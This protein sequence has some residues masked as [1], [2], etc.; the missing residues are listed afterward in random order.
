[1][2]PVLL[3]AALS[4]L[5]LPAP[6]EQVPGPVGELD[7]PVVVSTSDLRVVTYRPEHADAGELGR[8]AQQML[9]RRLYV[10]ERGLPSDQVLNIQLLGDALV[11]YDTDEYVGQ[12]L[13]T[14]AELD[15]P[16]KGK[17]APVRFETW[18]YTPRYLSLEAVYELLQPLRR[19]I[20]DFDRRVSS[21]MVAGQGV[22]NISASEERRLLVVRD[23]AERVGEIR[24]LL[25]RL[26]V[27]TDQVAITC[28]LLQG[29]AAQADGEGGGGALD[30]VFGQR[31]AAQAALPTEL[32]EHLRQLVPGQVFR[33]VGFGLLQT[34]VATRQSVSLQLSRVEDGAAGV[35]Y[36][37]LRPTA[38]DRESGSLTAESCTLSRAEGGQAALFSTSLVLRGGEFTVVGASGGTPLLVAIRVTAVGR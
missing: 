31:A 6:Q 11:L 12:M 30:D 2:S 36:L 34:S 26:D 10:K 15:Q 5:P 38:Y 29:S 27:P 33:Q 37:T 19:F 32:A 23:T 21:A 7:G 16:A 1:M 17:E 9:G 4:F 24:E 8:L 14:L 28:W 20:D 25:Q 3:L 18:E 13:A 35:F 22:L